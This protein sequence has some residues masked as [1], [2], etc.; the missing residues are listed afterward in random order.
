MRKVIGVSCAPIALL[1]CAFA[2]SLL[3]PWVVAQEKTEAMSD[4]TRP[5]GYQ[6]AAKRV[7]SWQLNSIFLSN[8]RKR[9]IIN[10][11]LVGVG[12]RVSGATVV[13]IE[14]GHVLLNT[15]KGEKLLRLHQQ[16]KRAKPTP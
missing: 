8:Q 14:S 1:A 16:V 13:R 11:Q 5:L 12:D 2:G 15:S 10:G 6:A 9:A 4:P 3:A 7:E